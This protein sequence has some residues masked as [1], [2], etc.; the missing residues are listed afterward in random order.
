MYYLVLQQDANGCDYSIACGEKWSSLDAETLE[1]AIQEAIDRHH[2]EEYLEE[3]DMQ[4][5]DMRILIVKDEIDL[6]GLLQIRKAKK[7]AFL[8]DI[9]TREEAHEKTEKEE[10]ERLKAKFETEI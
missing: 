1:E 5:S 4:C 10:Y 7:E 8:N 3:G 9:E 6:C 2:V